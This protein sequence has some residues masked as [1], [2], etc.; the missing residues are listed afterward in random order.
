MRR[1]PEETDQ[2]IN[3]GKFIF[4]GKSFKGKSIAA[5]SAT[6][7]IAAIEQSKAVSDQDK[8]IVFTC[9]LEKGPQ[10]LETS[11]ISAGSTKARGA[12]YAYI[13]RK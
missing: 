11:F 13:K 6:I 7:K 10:F 1:W 4:N 3:A 12:Y 2:A 8:E 9:H 5:N